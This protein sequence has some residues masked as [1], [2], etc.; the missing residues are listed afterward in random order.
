LISHK[1]SFN[2]GSNRKILHPSGG[3]FSALGPYQNIVTLVLFKLIPYVETTFFLR[4]CHSL[5][6]RY[7][8]ALVGRDCKK[9]LSRKTGIY[10]I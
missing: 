6:F 9:A 10:T 4:Y 5:L 7:R 2:L 8:Y 1:L 3:G